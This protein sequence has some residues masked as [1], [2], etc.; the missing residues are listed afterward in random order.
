MARACVLFVVFGLSLAG[1]GGDGRTSLD[2][3]TNNSNNNQP[4]DA[5]VPYNG[6]PSRNILVR[7]VL[8]GDT[9][10]VSANDSVLTPDGRSMDGEKVRLLGLDSPE[11]AHDPDPAD[12]GG[13]DARDFTEL[14]IEGRIITLEWDTTKCTAANPAGCRDDFGRLLGYVLKSG[15]VHNE[16]LLKTGNARVFGGARFRHRYS[17]RYAAIEA[18]A[19]AARLGLWA[20]P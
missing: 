2:G 3:G 18:E 20:C 10:I 12:C 5:G 9:I 13:D 11:I 19:R 7:Y 6:M 14:A 16:N 17:D 8:D 4:P 1:C 15:E